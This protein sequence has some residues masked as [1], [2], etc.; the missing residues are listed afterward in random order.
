MEMA[1]DVQIAVRSVVSR[2]PATGEI[3]REIACTPEQDVHQAVAR[4][5]EAQPRWSDLG[6]RRR[7]KILKNFQRL[8]HERKSRV[9]ELISREAG[10]PDVEALT[11]EVVV[12]LDSVRYYAENAFALL[13][14]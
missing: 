6:V 11:T 14:D 9:A 2:N 4:A 10:K 3:L 13:R 1:T 12:V 8:L 7:C 5:R